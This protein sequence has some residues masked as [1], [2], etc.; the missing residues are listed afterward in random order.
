MRGLLCPVP[1]ILVDPGHDGQVRL[2]TVLMV[3]YKDAS[4]ALGAI[5]TGVERVLHSVPED[6][7]R[8]DFATRE[9]YREARIRVAQKRSIMY[10]TVQIWKTDAEII[11]HAMRPIRERTDA[12]ECI[13][14]LLRGAYTH[15]REYTLSIT[16]SKGEQRIRECGELALR[17]DDFIL[18]WEH[19]YYVHTATAGSAA[20]AA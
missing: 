7:P 6:P 14:T 18:M 19:A 1:F 17:L 5:R 3:T 13:Y 16:R 2:K 11:N 20:S 8:R 15:M 4:T 9:E 10:A 12:R